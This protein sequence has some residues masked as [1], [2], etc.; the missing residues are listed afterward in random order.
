MGAPEQPDP[1]T[2]DHLH[3]VELAGGLLGDT[4]DAD[5]EKELDRI[6][7]GGVPYGFEDWYRLGR[8][9]EATAQQFAI[10]AYAVISGKP[11]DPSKLAEHLGLGAVEAFEA[12]SLAFWC[13][14]RGA[15]DE[16]RRRN[17]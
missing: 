11:F 12:G 5:R 3:L 13:W 16:H 6:A 17:P 7:R 9:Y 10:A 1:I 15:V 8:R 2:L 14:C 4:L